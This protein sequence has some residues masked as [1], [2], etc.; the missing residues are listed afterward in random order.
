M[1]CNEGFLKVQ[2]SDEVKLNI[3]QNKIESE[4]VQVIFDWL[5][6][7]IKSGRDSS[8]RSSVVVEGSEP[9]KEA[10]E[11]EFP[12]TLSSEFLSLHI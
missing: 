5:R 6:Y 4:T 7:I 8:P 9:Q 11:P 1:T 10:V 2:H 3:R 12:T